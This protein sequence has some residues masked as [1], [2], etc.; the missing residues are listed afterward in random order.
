M[1][2]LKQISN[3]KGQLTKLMNRVSEIRNEYYKKDKYEE[4]IKDK[5]YNN[6][7]RK[8]E[9]IALEL[10]ALKNNKTPIGE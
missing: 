10:D 5:N 2:R 4:L 8:A 3:L 9:K 1:D 7:M 6:L